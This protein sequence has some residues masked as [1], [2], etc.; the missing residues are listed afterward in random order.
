MESLLEEADRIKV[1][2]RGEIV[3]G[4]VMRIDQEGILVSIGHKSEGIVPPREMRSL[5]AEELSSLGMG[6]EV[7]IRVLSTESDQ[8]PAILSVD[9]AREEMGWRIVEEKFSTGEW[10]EGLITGHNRGGVLVDVSGLQGFV[11]ISHVGGFQRGADGGETDLDRRIGESLHLKVIEVDRSKR[12]AIFSEKMVLQ[13]RRES[14]RELILKELHEG[15][16]RKGRVT[17]VCDFGAFV[18]LGGADG[19]IHIS[20]LSWEPVQSPGQVVTVGEEVEVYVMK[21]DQEA[22]RI[23]LSLRRT[24]PQPWDTLAERYQVDQLVTG[25][26]TKLTHFGAFARIEG[27]VEGLIHISELSH[28]VINHPKEVVK[29]GDVLTLKILKIEP[30]RKRLALSIKQAEEF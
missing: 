27:S 13:E 16:I 19:L 30:E 15:E 10:V 21:V 8:G 2:R 9:Q 11:P 4:V 18:D 25:T 6:D 12:R 29:E 14:R 22:R 17:S 7:L 24:G 23:A 3:E 28:R 5:R 26:I 20:E 1:V